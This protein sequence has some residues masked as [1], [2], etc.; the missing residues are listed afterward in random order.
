M[1]ERGSEEIRRVQI[2]GRSSYIISL[3]KRWVREVGVVPGDQLTFQRQADGSMLI[4]PKPGR[5]ST[6]DEA[7]AII[8]TDES[9]N[10]IARRI[11]SL[12]LVGYGLISLTAKDGRI[13]SSQRETIKNVAKTKLI[14]TEI[15]EESSKE[16]SL[17]I[18]LGHPELS[19][20]NALR[21][22]SSMAMSMHRDAM[23]ALQELDYDL[24]NQV[25]SIDDEVDRFS[26]Y[27]IRQLKSSVQNPWLIKEIGLGG[28]RDLLGYRL[29]TASIESAAD[30][31]QDLAENVLAMK[32]PTTPAAL[33][34]ISKLSQRASSNFENSVK[35]LF[36]RNY[37]LADEVVETARAIE[38]SETEVVGFLSSVKKGD[39]PSLRLIVESV[40][41]TAEYAGNIGEVVLNLT[42]FDQLKERSGL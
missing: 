37:T 35:S 38:R 13:S 24:C 33:Q 26:L 10:S 20:E 11:I 25:V 1:L 34:R 4:L 17:Q 30:S 41:R 8:A 21:R 7:K 14:G 36:E 39:L 15:V 42:I 19:V 28:P 2:T 3:P 22:M 40:R 16:V 32:E 18:L 6:T 12:Y 27:L 5:K 23:L 9:P 29:I 31:A